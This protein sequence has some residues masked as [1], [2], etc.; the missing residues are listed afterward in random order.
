MN[1][2]RTTRT[3]RMAAAI[4]ATALCAPARGVH[5]GVEL[6]ARE[7][8]ADPL[9]AQPPRVGDVPTRM[10]DGLAPDCGRRAAPEHPVSML[11]AVDYTLCSSPAVAGSWAAIKSQAGAL[12][13]ARAAYFP[14]LSASLNQQRT[15]TTSEQWPGDVTAVSGHAISAALNWRLYD[16]GVRAANEQAAG[17]ML[18]AATA[19]LDATLQ[20]AI[21][22]TVQAFVDAQSARAVWRAS[23]DSVA[24]ARD[25]LASVRRREEAG[26]G[27]RGDTLQADSAH[28]KAVLDEIRALGAFRKAVA[29]L[30]FGMG[31]RADERLDLALDDDAPAPSVAG[32][33]KT[34]PDDDLAHWL[35]SAR[36]DHPAIRSARAQAEAASA[37]ARA[38]SA[39]TWP[40]VDLGLTWFKNGYPGQGLSRTASRVGTIGIAVTVPIF[41]GFAQRYKVGEMAARAE[42]K[43][44]AMADVDRE[45]SIDVVKAH[46]EMLSAFDS[47]AASKQLLEAAGDAERSARRKY[48]RGANDIVQVLHAQSALAEARLERARCVS[49]WRAARLRLMA[50]AGAL[51]LGAVHGATNY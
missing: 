45:V 12:G 2:K 36:S 16:F 8:A 50:S 48:D 5:G 41:D 26:A 15:R 35:A 34:P 6:P 13:R 14:T 18:L 3:Q 17:S 39:E 4:V 23:A 42:Q 25:T 49:A 1:A 40:T 22:S 47:L 33:A 28:A 11:E 31:L 27:A 10:P 51:G 19:D 32:E 30:R 38:A 46:A 20:R 24:N 37:G 9:A 21:G 29:A 7:W 43:Q 44:A